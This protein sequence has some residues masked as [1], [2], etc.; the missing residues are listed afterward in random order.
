VGEKRIDAVNQQNGNHHIRMESQKWEH[1]PEA[2]S[3]ESLDRGNS[4]TDREVKVSALV[5]DDMGRPKQVDHMAQTMVPIPNKVSSQEEQWP[6][7][8][9]GLYM[10]EGEPIIYQNKEIIENNAHKE[11]DKPFGNADIYIGN[12]IFIATMTTFT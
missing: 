3:N 7:P 5:V 10:E 1:R 12:G 9:V 8:P 11:M 4:R 6:C 2:I